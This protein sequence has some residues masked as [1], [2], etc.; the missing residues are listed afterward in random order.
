MT[1]LI[2]YEYRTLLLLGLVVVYVLFAVFVLDKTWP[3]AV[4]VALAL[5]T[6]AALAERYGPRIDPQAA[7][8]GAAS[9]KLLAIGAGTLLG[10]AVVLFVLLSGG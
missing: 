6:G 3:M 7:D 5:G 1:R 10:V 9:P 8:S 4:A 2:S